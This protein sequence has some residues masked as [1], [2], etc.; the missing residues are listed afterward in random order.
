MSGVRCAVGARCEMWITHIRL[1]AV[2]LVFTSRSEETSP[3]DMGL[4][5]L[6]SLHANWSERGSASTTFGYSIHDTSHCLTRK[7][8]QVK[9]FQVTI[10]TMKERPTHLASGNALTHSSM[11]IECSPSG[12]TSHLTLPPMRS[13]AFC[14]AAV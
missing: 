1:K 9:R 13:I 6:M 12:V 3:V 11:N 7:F 14:V 5:L 4:L 8:N 10:G 2:R